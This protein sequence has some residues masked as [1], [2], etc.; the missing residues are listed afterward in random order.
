[1]FYW[2]NTCIFDT[3]MW[4][5]RIWCLNHHAPYHS[6]KAHYVNFCDNSFWSYASNILCHLIDILF[7]SL[8]SL[9]KN[10]NS[11]IIDISPIYIFITDRVFSQIHCGKYF[12]IHKNYVQCAEIYQTVF[13]FQAFDRS[14]SHYWRIW[15]TI[16]SIHWDNHKLGIK[17][18]QQNFQ[19]N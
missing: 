8:H 11:L 19:W 6:Y 16:Q 7:L 14:L 17:L 10:L 13:I 9:T 18:V 4:G 2:S 1:M 5:F 15:W 12:Y 3:Y